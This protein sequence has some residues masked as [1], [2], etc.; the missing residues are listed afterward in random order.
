MPTLAR[1]LARAKWTRTDG[2]G[3]GETPA[4]AITRDLKTDD[5]ALSFWTVDA[6]D[7][8][9]WSQ[10]ALALCSKFERL[11]PFDV[12]RLDRDVL[13]QGQTLLATPGDTP[14]TDLVPRHVDVARLDGRRLLQVSDLVA[15]VARADGDDVVRVSKKQ[16]CS[17]LADAI[18][19][20]R[21]RL[22]DLSES[23]RAEVQEELKR[24][25]P[26]E[27]GGGRGQ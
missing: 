15:A 6:A 26:G 18:E 9:W 3:D 27:P 11:D 16:A 10:A 20:T 25:A 21:L 24:R 22:E 1:K 7:D 8:P 17:L 5:N 23:V 13:G 4:D 12:A 2:L 19:A 14:V